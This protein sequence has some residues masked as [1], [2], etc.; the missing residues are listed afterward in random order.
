MLEFWYR[1]RRTLLDFRR[2]PLGP[3]LDGFAAYLKQAGYSSAAGK[4][5]LA[6]SCQFNDWL[7]RNG[8]A[9]C[10]GISEAQLESFLDDRLADVR[11]TST[12]YHPRS[13]VRCSLKRLQAYLVGEGILDRPKPKPEPHSWYSHVLGLFVKYLHDECELAEQT[14][15]NIRRMVVAFLEGSRKGK[16]GKPNDFLNPDALAQYVKV[17]IA[18][19]PENLKSHATAL[20]KFL[21]FCAR[22]GHTTTDL[23]GLIPSVRSYRQASLPRGMEDSDLERVLATIPR[24]TPKGAKD[25]AIVLLMMGY[26]LRS[27]SVAALQLEDIRWRSSTIRIRAQKGGKEA[28]LP[29]LDAVGEAV[30]W[31]LRHR[32]DS[33]FREV[34][35]TTKAPIHPLNGLGISQMTRVYMKRAGVS[36]PGRGAS[37]LRHSWAIRALAHDS[38]IKAIADVLG[39]RYLNT[40]FIY[41]KADLKALRHVAMPWPEER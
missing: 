3:Y 9:T 21:R 32:P 18:Q 1:D 26:G 27:V 23:S 29:L 39:H 4:A 19:S 30:L 8:V 6:R 28:V 24:D 15:G 25:Y 38:S 22:D 16:T 36:L 31:Y 12:N 41:A 11:T 33:P 2:G 13:D 35:L 40:T 37:T 10:S 34:F 7:V 20:R 17:H 14:V 5:I